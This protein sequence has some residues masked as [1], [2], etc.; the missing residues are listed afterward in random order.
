MVL[1][2]LADYYEILAQDENSGIPLAGYSRAPVS[3]ALVL[4]QEGDLVS[5]FPLK[6]KTQK[7]NKEFSPPMLVPEQVKKTSGVSSNFLCENAAYVLGIAKPDK[8]GKDKS[9]RAKECFDDFRLLHHKILDELDCDEARAVLAFLDAW[10][11]EEAAEHSALGECLEQI[12]DGGNLVFRL[13]GKS[14]FVHDHPLIQRAW[15]AYK[16]VPDNAPVMRCLVSGEQAPV[17]RIH[18][19]FKGIGGTNPTLISFDKDS[20]AYSSFGK[21]GLQGYNAPVS[22]R[23]SFA[24]GTALQYLLSSKTNRIMLHAKR[25]PSTS[26]NKSP[27][28]YAKKTDSS[29]SVTFWALT[30]EKKYELSLYYLF[31]PDEAEIIVDDKEYRD[32][33]FEREL[34]DIF[35]KIKI[36]K[37]LIFPDNYNPNIIFYILGL[38]AVKG[39]VAVRFFYKNTF[40]NIEKNITQHYLDLQTSKQFKSNYNYIPVHILLAQTLPENSDKSMVS[41]ALESALFRSI[42]F[43]TPYP[44]TMYKA[45]LLRI[46]AN[47]DINYYKAAII[48]AYLIR[49]KLFEE[50]LTMDLCK[51]SKCK[52]YDLGRLFALLERI[53]YEAYA[54]ESPKIVLNSTIKDKFFTSACTTPKAVFPTLIKRMEHHISNLDYG[55]IREKEL[56]EIVAGLEDDGI[57][58]NELDPF[59]AN[60]ALD[61]QGVFLYGYYQQRNSYYKGKKN[62]EEEK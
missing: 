13:D 20:D 28:E 39:R 21:D 35:K 11:P 56:A 49:K 62:N 33:L 9:T 55:Y 2:S 41:P 38:S 43:G 19:K 4:T 12:S 15:E 7:G 26:N 16:A 44:I 1:Q 31:N 59:P 57:T 3:Y 40:G 36:G 22:K 17:E 51:N 10:Q 48:K 29:T 27:I 37:P 61:E 30:K 23:V 5:V 60:L 50:V 53:Q 8:S 18:A 42:L 45:V 54:K 24:Y 34:Y 47:D 52:A 46:F 58:K 14:G 32:E 6:Q 25:L